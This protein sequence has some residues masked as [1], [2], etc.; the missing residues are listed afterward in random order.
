LGLFDSYDSHL[1]PLITLGGLCVGLASACVTGTLY[2]VDFKNRI[3]NQGDTIVLLEQRLAKLEARAP[4]SV[5]MIGPEGPRGADG[6]PGRQ[7]EPGPQGE[8][9]FK[10]DPGAKGDSGQ[11]QTAELERRI[12]NL[13]ARIA[14][15][16]SRAATQ[17]ATISPGANFPSPNGMLRNADGCYSYPPDKETVVGLF[18]VNDKFCGLDGQVAMAITRVT[19]DRFWFR[20]QY[21]ERE[22]RMALPCIPPPFNTQLRMRP[23]RVVLD[24]S[25]QPRME[26]EFARK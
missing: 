25:G 8:R 3:S 23:N 7:G 17:Y 9:G 26:I 19:D 13:E 15:D 24:A 11:P 14:S 16:S 22:C 1:K 10:G 20:S 2:Y 21:G 6:K 12:A 18:S 5:G 4:G